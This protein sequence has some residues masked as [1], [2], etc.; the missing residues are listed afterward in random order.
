MCIDWI[1][2]R[3]DYAIFQRPLTI[4]SHPRLA[5]NRHDEVLESNQA[6]T[7]S[8]A[9]DAIDEPSNAVETAIIA[10]PCSH[11]S[12]ICLDASSTLYSNPHP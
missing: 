4:L 8:F 12:R 9:R 7:V 3:T 2:G 1:D 6:A 10:L 11:Q 5:P